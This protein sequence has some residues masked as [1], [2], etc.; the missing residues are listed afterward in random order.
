MPTIFPKLSTTGRPLILC[1]SISRAAADIDASEATETTVGVMTSFAYMGVV[2][3]LNGS[4]GLQRP[5]GAPAPTG[6]YPRSATVEARRRSARPEHSHQ[7]LRVERDRSLWPGS[8]RKAHPPA[9]RPIAPARAP[10]LRHPR[11]ATGL[12]RSR[13]GRINSTGPYVEPGDK[14]PS[15][16]VRAAASITR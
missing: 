3:G 12:S 8:W 15:E 2:P 9:D 10:A 11:S 7:G 6:K 14:A 13:S 5:R 16:R 1:C 4:P